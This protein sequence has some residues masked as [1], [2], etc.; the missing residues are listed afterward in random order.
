MRLGMVLKS[1]FFMTVCVLHSHE[2][3]VKAWVKLIGSFVFIIKGRK[4]VFRK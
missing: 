4:C 2:C 3:A 1:A